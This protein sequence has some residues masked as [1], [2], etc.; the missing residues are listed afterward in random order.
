MKEILHEFFPDSINKKLPNLYIS[1]IKKYIA[2]SKNV[3]YYQADIKEFYDNINRD[4]LTK[5]IDGRVKNEIFN[6]MLSKALNSPTV[7]INISPTNRIQYVNEFGIPQGLSISNVL[8]NIYLFDLDLSLSKRKYLYLRFVDDM[9]ILSE[10]KLP[11]AS[12]TSIVRHLKVLNLE[13]NKSKTH[14][15][16]LADGINYLGYNIGGK[17]SVSAANIQKFISSIA[18][19]FTHF[20]LGFNNK[21][22]RPAW[23]GDDDDMF[24]EVFIN[25][26]NERITGAINDN[27]RFGWLFFF[28][29]I[30]DKNLLFKLDK[31]I[32]SFFLSI[33]A[34]DHKPAPNLKKLVRT[35][36]EIKYNASTKYILNY[37]NHDST[38]K[39]AKFLIHRGVLNPAV[40]YDAATIKMYYERFK[41]NQLRKLEKDVGYSYI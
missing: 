31:I 33:S 16:H 21:S 13:T 40:H 12:E 26:L 23:L 10:G 8:A 9:L 4:I 22:K 25:A 11:S 36:H 35:Y 29:E 38:V 19:L 15:G 2:K 5:K 18:A 3:Q 34:F 20:K 28:S 6:S 41:Q 37:N 14:N 32:E 24:K 7:P 17:I 27:R 39:K 1:Q 30:T